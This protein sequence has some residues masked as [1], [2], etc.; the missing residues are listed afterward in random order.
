LA[1]A[2]NQQFE[3]VPPGG[4]PAEPIMVC[5]MQ[6]S[7]QHRRSDVWLLEV[8]AGHTATIPD[9]TKCASFGEVQQMLAR[10]FFDGDES[11]VQLLA[12][13]SGEVSDT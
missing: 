9:K 12:V 10:C 13:R 4:N 5:G 6:E 8:P 3:F 7:D 1:L 2:V 11:K